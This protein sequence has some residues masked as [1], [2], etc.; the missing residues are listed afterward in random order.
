MRANELLFEYRRD[1]TANALGDKLIAALVNTPLYYCPDDLPNAKTLFDMAINPQHYDLTTSV[2]YFVF[3]RFYIISDQESAKTAANHIKAQTID[4]ILKHIEVADPTS[5]K[6]YSQWLARVWANQVGRWKIEDLNRNDVLTAYHLGKSKNLIKPE[7][8]DIN[9][10]KTYEE[11][12]K[13]IRSNYDIN[14]LLGY[15]A[16]DEQKGKYKILFDDDQVTLVSILDLTASEYWGEKYNPDEARRAEWCTL[17]P[18]R[19]NQY[20]RQ[21]PL[22][23]IRPKKE[24]IYGEKYQIHFESDQFMN[25]DDD[26]INLYNLLTKRFPQLKDVFIKLNPDLKNNVFFCEDE[27]LTEIW[28]SIVDTAIFLINDEIEDWVVGDEL[29]H[30]WVTEKAIENGFD[31]EGDASLVDVQDALNIS[32]ADYIKIYYPEIVS[33][34]RELREIKEMPIEN[35]R[36]QALDYLEEKNEES[37][38]DPNTDFLENTNMSKLEHIL[39]YCVKELTNNPEMIQSVN[40]I[41]KHIHIVKQSGVGAIPSVLKYMK[42]TNRFEPVAEISGWGIFK[43]NY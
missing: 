40:L 37:Y 18:N 3:N 24:S 43:I 41:E 34:L 16:S 42:E 8:K 25:E 23:V 12:E 38:D 10:F 28:S 2:K 19:F 33:F 20:I 29:Y 27:T 26:P 22:Y 21:G 6:M 13:T 11:F 39:A 30:E 14:V 5:N 15:E 35:I 7:H 1:V 31:I 17:Q 36:G 32:Y 9:K 4:T